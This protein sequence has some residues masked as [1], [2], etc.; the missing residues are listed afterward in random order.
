MTFQL[1]ANRKSSIKGSGPAA[2][3][4]HLALEC[5]VTLPI[6]WAVCAQLSQL[7]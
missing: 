3:N 4:Q 6:C 2:L 7:V 5:R 1:T